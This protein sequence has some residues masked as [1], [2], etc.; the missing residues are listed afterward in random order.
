MKVNTAVSAYLY[1]GRNRVPNT[2]IREH[3]IVASIEIAEAQVHGVGEF[4]PFLSK[5]HKIDRRE[6]L[7]AFLR[8]V[9]LVRSLFYYAKIGARGQERNRGC[10]RQ[11][12]SLFFFK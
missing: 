2:W 5:D 4:D 3:E 1:P 8:N 11:T 7:P 12:R 6:G 10:L 9:A